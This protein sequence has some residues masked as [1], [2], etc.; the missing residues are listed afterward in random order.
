MKTW[1]RH[2]ERAESKRLLSAEQHQSH[3]VMPG[4][5]AL[6]LWLESCRN[7]LGKDLGRWRSGGLSAGASCIPSSRLCREEQRA[8]SWKR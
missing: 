1:W 4:Q 3:S 8:A 7:P 2:S 5:P 6:P